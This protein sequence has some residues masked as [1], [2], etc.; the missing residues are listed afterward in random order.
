MWSHDGT[1]LVSPYIIAALLTEFMTHLILQKDRNW[2]QEIPQRSVPMRILNYT[3][4][5]LL[6]ACLGATDSSPFIYFQF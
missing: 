4:L 1:R 3:A 2:A 5:A 6:I